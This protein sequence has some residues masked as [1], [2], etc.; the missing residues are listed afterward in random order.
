MTET[1]TAREHVKE[2]NFHT[3]KN[4]NAVDELTNS[5]GST[6]TQSATTAP[7]QHPFIN[8]NTASNN[9]LS[10]LANNFHSANHRE[11]SAKY[12]K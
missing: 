11:A 3:N 9:Q 8:A 7:G 4:C 12:I 1:V 10:T 6:N 5:V 2:T